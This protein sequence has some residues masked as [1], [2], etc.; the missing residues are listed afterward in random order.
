MKIQFTTNQKIVLSFCLSTFFLL[1]I[2]LFFPFA[3]LIFYAPFLIFFFYKKNLSPSLWMAFVCGAIMDLVTSPDMFGTYIFN[4]CVTT[5]ILHSQRKN[6]FEDSSSTLPI[7]T[8]LFALISTLILVISF[9]A[10]GKGLNLSFSWIIT[11]LLIMPFF[12]SLYAFLCFSIFM[13]RSSQREYF[14]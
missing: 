1:T 5:L 14:F 8:F 6:F 7:M 2:P 3:K 10:I 4:Y 13:P 11:D 9:E 12:D